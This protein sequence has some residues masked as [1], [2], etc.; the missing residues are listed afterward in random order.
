MNNEYPEYEAGVLLNCPQFGQNN[1]VTSY[2]LLSIMIRYF[3]GGSKVYVP[4]YKVLW[5]LFY[6]KRGQ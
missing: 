4:V 3:D 1:V 5:G 2:V 6:L